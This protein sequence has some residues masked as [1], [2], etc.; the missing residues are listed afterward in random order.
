MFSNFHK[1]SLRFN[2]LYP[3]E[4]QSCPIVS[5]Q[6][7]G[8]QSLEFLKMSK[9]VWHYLLSHG[10]VITAEYLPSKLN[11]QAYWET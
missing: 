11:I 2:Y 1:E 4:Q 9:L 5:L 7:W 10:T 8:I 6:N 3:D